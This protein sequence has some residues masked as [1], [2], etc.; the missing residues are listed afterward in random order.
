[1]QKRCKAAGIPCFQK[2]REWMI[3]AL[4]ARSVGVEYENKTAEWIMAEI[5]KKS[6]GLGA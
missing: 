4:K 5:A 3:A 6:I 2:G 1:M